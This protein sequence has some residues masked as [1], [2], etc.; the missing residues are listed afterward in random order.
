MGFEP[1]GVPV[2]SSAKGLDRFREQ[3]KAEMKARSMNALRTP[4]NHR[5]RT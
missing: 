5:L 3:Y 4:V 2:R 1:K